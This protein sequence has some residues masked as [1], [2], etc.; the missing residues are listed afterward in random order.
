MASGL[1][2][3]C[4]NWRAHLM[5]AKLLGIIPLVML[6][7]LEESP[8]FLL[9]KRRFKEAACALTKIAKFNGKS[10]QRFSAEEM[11]RM[12]EN[13][14]RGIAKRLFFMEN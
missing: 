8:R 2:V 12:H 14:K 5:I 6:F 11:E 9:E 10:E 4:R 13:S 1:A 3:L 7:K